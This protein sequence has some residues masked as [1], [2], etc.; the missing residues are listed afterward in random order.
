MTALSV[1][2]EGSAGQEEGPPRD[3]RILYG[4][5]YTGDCYRGRAQPI[6]GRARD[7]LS[8]RGVLASREK[9]LSLTT[10]LLRARK[11]FH[12]FYSNCL[13]ARVL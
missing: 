13:N 8:G 11:E 10:L 7:R 3:D 12:W 4:R 2:P 5:Q 9:V 1:G 6:E